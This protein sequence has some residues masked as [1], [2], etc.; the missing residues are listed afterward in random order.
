MYR[1]VVTIT[2]CVSCRKSKTKWWSDPK[3]IVDDIPTHAFFFK[4]IIKTVGTIV[5]F[6]FRNAR[7][8]LARRIGASSITIMTLCGGRPDSN[9]AETVGRPACDDPIFQVDNN[10]TERFI[11]EI[12]LPDFDEKKKNNNKKV[13]LS[14]KYKTAR[15]YQKYS[16]RRHRKTEFFDLMAEVIGPVPILLLHQQCSTLFSILFYSVSIVYFRNIPER[17]YHGYLSC[18]HELCSRKTVKRLSEDF[19]IFTRYWI[20]HKQQNSALVYRDDK[21]SI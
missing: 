9:A 6:N 13:V 19:R 1:I 8:R 15:Y 10:R 17:P 3:I 21:S 11:A 7:S 18:N 14:S 20:V 12:I 4:H 5:N 2:H 16:N